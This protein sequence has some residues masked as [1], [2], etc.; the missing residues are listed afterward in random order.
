MYTA[1]K[2]VLLPTT[3]VGSWPRPT[4]FTSNLNRRTFSMGMNDLAYRE[5]FTDA[6]SLVVTDQEYAG[7]DIL[8]NGDYHLDNDWSGRSWHNYPLE[9]MAGMSELDLDP[10]SPEWGAPNGTY[11]NEIQSGWRFPRVVGKVGPGAGL[12]FAKIWRT[13]QSRAAKPVKFGTNT[14]DTLARVVT[15]EAGVYTDDERQLMWDIA[16]VINQELRELVAAGCR[17][18]QIEDPTLHGA[19]FFG[20]PQEE[21]DFLVDLFNH[22][23]SGLEEAEV[24]VHTCWGNPGAQG[25]DKHTR[26]YTD[27][28]IET[29]FRL[30]IDV[31][32]I[33]S[34]SLNH[35]P[36]RLFGR[37]KGNLPMKIAP[38]FISHRVLQVESPEEVAADIR[39][40]LEFIDAEHLVLTSDCGFGR[41]G[42][43]RPIAL[44]K[45]SALA[46]GAN[47]VRR[48]L[49]GEEREIPAL[50]PHRQIDPSPLSPAR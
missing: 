16:T 20:L 7:L 40:A 41:Q 6:V 13:S 43:S 30:N 4:W 3:V 25:M 1:T 47:I 2:D 15:T 45:A 48:E 50:D 9:R 31:L 27:H 28:A 49:G 12:E 5:Q 21:I 11:M 19:A 29:H 23:V 46:Q 32:N 33:E 35:E 44:Y 17:V 26:V 18:V 24:W 38:G 34:K 36:L 37:F 42:A 14:A 39:G 22:E 8:T 10:T